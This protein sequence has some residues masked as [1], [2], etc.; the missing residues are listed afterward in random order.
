MGY[1]IS[2]QRDFKDNGLYIEVAVGGKVKAGEDILTIRYTGEQKNLV[3]PRDA[4]NI[5]ES[6]YRSWEKDYGDER[7]KL[8]IVGLTTPLVYEFSSAGVAAAKQWANKVF[9]GMKKCGNTAC[10]KAMGSRDPYEHDDLANLV[11]CTEL[12]CAR[13]YRDTFG[14]EPP[15]IAS[16]KEKKQKVFKK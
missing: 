8:R 2:R 3:D 7:K 10:G 5:A 14:T 4:I 1:F 6:I 15:R 12:C 9:E 11:F 13:K 16:N